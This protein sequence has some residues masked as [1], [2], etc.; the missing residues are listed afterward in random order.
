MLLSPRPPICRGSMSGAGGPPGI[1]QPG[2]LDHEQEPVAD[3][4]E[5]PADDRADDVDPGVV[6][7]AGHQRGAEPARRV[8]GRAGQ[9]ADR[10]S[11]RG[12]AWCR[13]PAAAQCALA[14]GFMAT[15]ITA[16]TSKKVP[17][18]S[19]TTP[20]NELPS[21]LKLSATAPDV[22]LV[23][24][25]RRAAGTSSSARRRR[26][27]RAAAG[28]RRSP[29]LGPDRAQRHGGQRDRRVDV[30]ARDVAERRHDQ[31]QNEAVHERRRPPSRVP[32]PCGLTNRHTTRV[33][34]KTRKNVPR[35]SATYEAG[36]FCSTDTSG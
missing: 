20:A 10:S 3:R 23:G 6:P 2:P 17:S 7:L 18:P 21:R 13:S 19:A 11:R 28:C 33:T 4:R 14:R 15:P 27:P 36:D 31:E 32:V 8:D 1:V 34:A 9:R 29:S 25:R 26:R 12:P 24:E 5:Q 35:N 22:L 30:R 16:Q